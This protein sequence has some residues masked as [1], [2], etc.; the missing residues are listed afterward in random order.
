MSNLEPPRDPLEVWWQYGHVR[1]GALVPGGP[2]YV[3]ATLTKE[4]AAQLADALL[5]CLFDP[6]AK[7]VDQ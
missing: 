3:L 6:R 1:I 4:Q 5:F 7:G 2:D